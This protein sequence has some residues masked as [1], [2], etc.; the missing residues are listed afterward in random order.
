MLV[1]TGPLPSAIHVNLR[2][3]PRP[4]QVVGSH[5]YRLTTWFPEQAYFSARG[6][7]VGFPPADADDRFTGLRFQTLHLDRIIDYT[8]IAETILPQPK[9]N[10]A[11]E[12]WARE[13]AS[14]YHM[15]TDASGTT[16]SIGFDA[17]ARTADPYELYVRYAS[18]DL[19][20]W[21]SSSGRH[22]SD[23]S[24]RS[25]FGPCRVVTCT[26]CQQTFMMY[27]PRC[28]AGWME[29][30]TCRGNVRILR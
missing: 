2:E 19:M 28:P 30:W 18:L 25:P 10:G 15:W 23:G 5:S 8:P 17:R 29:A 9:T 22:P 14:R 11:L 4:R 3:R 24:V 6:A 12:W 7:L 1:P 20:T 26:R 16:L 13:R 21:L 27:G